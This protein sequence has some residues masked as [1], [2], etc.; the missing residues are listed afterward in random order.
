M[1]TINFINDNK[2]FPVSTEGLDFLQN[3]IKQAHQLALIGGSDKYIL[4][5]CLNTTGNTWSEGMV[6]VNG[7]L[8]PF[9]GGT[10]TLTSNVRIKQTTADI[11]AGYDTYSNAYVTRYVEF[12]SN[13]GGVDT[14]VWNTFTRVKSNLQLAAE[15]ATKTE[16]QALS[17]LMMPKGGIIMWSGTTAAIPTGYVLCDGANSTSFGGAVPDLRGRFICGLDPQITTSTVATNV[18]DMTENY[19]VVGSTGGKP[20]LKLVAA[21]IPQLTIKGRGGADD[22]NFSNQ[23]SLSGSDK[24]IDSGWDFDY[25]IGNANPNSIENRP[26]YYVLA[27]IIKV[28]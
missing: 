15:S 13:T 1:N 14:Y 21:N 28:V 22:K 5:G 8:L 23:D 25:N 4:K 6:V 16:L 18:T 3:I 17:N 19:G 20:N 9:V 2:E 24:P 12:G 10:G 26:Q 11:V 27:F 7:E